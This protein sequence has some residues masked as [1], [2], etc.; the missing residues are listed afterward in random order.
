M[1]M[2]A[3]VLILVLAAV[4]AVPA[5]AEKTITV[6]GWTK[7]GFAPQI[8]TTP[9]TASETIGQRVNVS[10]TVDDYVTAYARLE[11]ASLTYVGSIGATAT[12]ALANNARFAYGY[13][14]INLAKFMKL[15]AQKIG[16][17]FR[18]GW[19]D[20]SD[21]SYVSTSQY[22][23]E[24]IANAGVGGGTMFHV[25]ASYSDLI[26]FKF[27]MDPGAANDYF[28]AL[29]HSKKYGNTTIAGEVVLDA[30]GAGLGSGNLIVDLEVKPTMGDLALDIGAGMR[31]GLA[32]SSLNWGAGVG[33]SYTTL[34]RVRAGVTGDSTNALSGLCVDVRFIPVAVM[35]I[36][37]AVKLAVMPAFAF[38]GADFCAMFNIGAADLYLGAVVRDGSTWGVD[39]AT[40]DIAPYVKMEVSY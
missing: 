34:A 33:V 13:M 21:N 14:D 39:K 5:M 24:N 20:S 10:V 31:Y 4:L 35:E 22:G 28:F 40:N 38:T 12:S 18:G 11:L 6:G 16:L 37:G 27:A 23:I 8:G 3:A 17:N 7:Y 32:A 29:Y 36:Y 25:I 15:D 2:R 26:T 19:M 9:L 1:R 30:A